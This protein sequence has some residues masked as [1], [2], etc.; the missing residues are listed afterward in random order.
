MVDTNRYPV[1]LEWVNRRVDVRLVSDEVI[2]TITGEEPV[3]Y[4]RLEGRYQF[5]KWR[6]GTRTWQAS[7][8]EVIGRPR[9][10]PVY[11]D[12]GGSVEVRGLEVYEAIAQEVA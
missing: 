9:L 11:R 1:P 5:A 4:Q 12:E 10:D 6:G 8:R 7:R 3:S 2:I